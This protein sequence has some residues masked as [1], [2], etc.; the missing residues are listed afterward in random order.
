MAVSHQS[1]PVSTALFPLLLLETECTHS[2]GRRVWY[3]NRYI[4]NDGKQT[5][6]QWAL[7]GQVVRDFVDGEEEILVR[8]CADD[9]GR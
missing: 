8:S 6:G 1:V 9:V 3:A 4:G 5:V 7:K 2:E